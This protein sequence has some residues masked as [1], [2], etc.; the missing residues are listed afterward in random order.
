MS[1]NFKYE[2]KPINKLKANFSKRK[3]ADL[4]SFNDFEDFLDWYNLQEKK[5]YYCGVEE[6]TVQ[7]IIMTSLLKS[8]RFPNDGKI[9]RGQSRG[10][11]LEVDRLTPKENYS[12]ENCVL[13]CYFCNNDKSDVFNGADYMDF[14]LDR[15][16]YLKKLLRNK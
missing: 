10:V 8:S 14:K 15:V 9:G 7:E 13:A 2:P 5:C 16:G 6:S 1:K 12:R 3:S 11:W 4:N